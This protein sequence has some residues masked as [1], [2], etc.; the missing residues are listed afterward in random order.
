ME[1]HE[2]RLAALGSGW[3]E[4]VE[5]EMH[6]HRAHFELLM[7][8]VLGRGLTNRMPAFRLSSRFRRNRVRL[9]MAVPS[10]AGWRVGYTLM[11]LSKTKWPCLTRLPP[12]DFNVVSPFLSI[13]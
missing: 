5:C 8:D 6:R 4:L 11:I 1:L 10:R 7:E 13:E 12:Y 9:G 2:S 3:P